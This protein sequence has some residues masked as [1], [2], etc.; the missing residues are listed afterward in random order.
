MINYSTAIILINPDT[1]R[2]VKGQYEERGLEEVFKT[3]DFGL[4]VGDMVAVE[5]ATRWNMTTVKITAVDVE[6]DYD[7]DKLVRWVV[8]KIDM[9]QHA[10][11]QATEAEA[12]DL[13]KRGEHR[14]RREDI[15]ANTLG[16]MTPE[17][18]AR[19]GVKA[20]GNNAITDGTKG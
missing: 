18:I 12:I 3:T 19:L 5:S 11:V 4:K 13:I 6:P 14:K 7:S 8:Q 1:I 9:E 20:I 16:A 15:R 17:E 2:C 10:K